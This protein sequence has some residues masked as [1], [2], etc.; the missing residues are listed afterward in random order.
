MWLLLQVRGE[1][2]GEL[3]VEWGRSGEE[4]NDNGIGEKYIEG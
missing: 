3:T 4:R 2:K 1:G